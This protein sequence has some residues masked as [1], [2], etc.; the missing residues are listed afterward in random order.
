[1]EEAS[2]EERRRR[3]EARRLAEE[4]AEWREECQRAAELLGRL[5]AEQRSST[6]EARSHHQQASRHASS[7]PFLPPSRP[8]LR[9]QNERR[10]VFLSLLII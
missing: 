10:V 4:V 3:G 1:M 7:P 2:D 5:H 6:A 8:L 9:F